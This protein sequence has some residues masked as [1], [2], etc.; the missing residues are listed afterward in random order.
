[1]AYQLLKAN[2]ELPLE[3]C[4]LAGD[5]FVDDEA[6]CENKKAVQLQMQILLW[7]GKEKWNRMTVKKKA[8]L[9]DYMYKKHMVLLKQS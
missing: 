1:M 8:R 6:I 3:L 2:T 7:W 9:A 4:E 5:M